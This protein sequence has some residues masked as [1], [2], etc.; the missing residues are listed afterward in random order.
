MDASTPSARELK[1]AILKAL[2]SVRHEHKFT[3]LGRG[4]QQGTLERVLAIQ[5]EARDRHIAAKA[6]AEL[7]SAGL[8][9]PTYEDLIDPESWFPVRLIA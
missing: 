3:I 6:F 8:I 7:E 4:N 5:F 1:I 2:S 9:R